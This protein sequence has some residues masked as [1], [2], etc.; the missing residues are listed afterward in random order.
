MADNSPATVLRRQLSVYDDDQLLYE[1]RKNIATQKR[2]PASIEAHIAREANN[3]LYA[4]AARRGLKGNAPMRKKNPKVWTPAMRAAFAAKMKRARAVARGGRRKN[5]SRKYPSYTLADLK[6]F[7]AEGK[8]N[9][10]MEQE[11]KDRESGSSTVRVTPQ[12]LGGRVLLPRR[13]NPT[14]S[15]VK[16]AAARIGRAAAKLT[17]RGAKLTGRV[18]R[19][20]AKAAAR[21]VRDSICRPRAKNPK[22]A[23]PHMRFA[24]KAGS[25]KH[26]VT[27]MR[28]EWERDA[29]KFARVFAKA[30]PGMRV[31]VYRV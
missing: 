5:P 18:G 30:N 13:K 29:V 12:I 14:K 24:V 20:S 9:A 27:Q 22:R 31:G 25:A 6:K 10:V 11:I 4:E 19:E 21:E 26:F 17:W 3:D 8:G 28:F 7:V 16:A 15:E 2:Q 1:I 23:R